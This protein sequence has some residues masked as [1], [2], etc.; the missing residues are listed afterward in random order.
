M[1]KQA[2]LSVVCILFTAFLYAT[3]NSDS[4]LFRLDSLVDKYE[5]VQFDH[6]KHVSI[7]NN[8]GTCHHEHGK[9]NLLCMDCHSI[10]K[11][12][13][14]S[15]VVRSFTACKNCHAA[16]NRDNPGM[17]GLKAAYHQVCFD[18]HRGMGNVG[19]E[20]KGCT[21]ICHAKKQ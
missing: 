21:E 2:I 9:N 12:T 4:G 6:A 11:S 13:F 18:C 8:C 5:A 15:S 10:S 14:Q 20:P 3:V 19:T 16:V 17:P 7:A 1:K